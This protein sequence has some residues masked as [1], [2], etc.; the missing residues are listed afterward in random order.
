MPAVRKI[1]ENV[2]D[3]PIP[4]ETA[5]RLGNPLR[6]KPFQRRRLP[7]E[8]RDRKQEEI[9]RLF[10]PFSEKSI[11]KLKDYDKEL[12]KMGGEEKEEA[13]ALT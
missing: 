9:L 11:R 4:L 10:D 13:E 3:E 1:I 12:E 6:P 7:R 8:K 5:K 2:L